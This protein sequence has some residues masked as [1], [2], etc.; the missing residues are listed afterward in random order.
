MRY[1]V[2]R[3]ARRVSLCGVYDEKDVYIEVEQTQAAIHTVL[4]YG[5]GC[6]LFT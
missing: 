2:K 4:H 5:S 6:M 3:Q 1:I